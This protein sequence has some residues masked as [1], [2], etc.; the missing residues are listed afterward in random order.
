M[1]IAASSVA[2]YGRAGLV[3]MQWLDTRG[4]GHPPVTFLE[5][6]IAL[7]QV[8]SVLGGRCCRGAWLPLF[9]VRPHVRVS[10]HA[11]MPIQAYDARRTQSRARDAQ[12]TCSTRH[13]RR[14]H[15][16][17]CTRMHTHTHTHTRARTQ[18]AHTHAAHTHTRT[19]ARTQGTHTR[20]HTRTHS[21][22]CTH[23]QRIRTRSTFTYTAHTCMLTLPSGDGG[24]SLWAA[25]RCGEGAVPGQPF[26]EPAELFEGPF[27]WRGLP[28]VPD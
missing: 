1:S 27:L 26:P 21:H 7:E 5:L 19:H 2:A 9:H 17:S 12:H 4:S 16:H 15:T 8:C 3:L 13:T 6:R 20:T 18:H 28:G 24:H 23:T 11:C 25:L 14:V 10:F 22:R